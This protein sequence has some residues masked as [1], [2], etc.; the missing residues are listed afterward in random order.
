MVVDDLNVGGSITGPDEAQPPLGID[1]NA[2]LAL[3]IILER[4]KAVPWRY[5]QVIENPGPVELGELAEG[6]ALDVHPSSYPTAF[7]EGLGV[8]ALE[9]LDRHRWILT[10]SVHS[11][12]R[13]ARHGC[14]L[15]GL[16]FTPAASA[17]CI[18]KSD[19]LL[20]SSLAGL[21]VPELARN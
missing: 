19:R 1:A 18:A 21:S 2:V 16:T 9:A 4:F 5:L 17:P 11:V 7:K 12:K 13:E 15:C 10:R 8:F 3:P 6:R 14:C 20:G